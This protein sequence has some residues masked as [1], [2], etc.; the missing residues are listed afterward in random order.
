M[1]EQLTA[2]YELQS[3]D[4]KIVHIRTA[5]AGFDGAKVLKQQLAAAKSTAE[6]AHA[7]LTEYETELKDSELRLK[8]IDDK[9]GSVEK[10]LY[11]G[12]VSNTR[13]LQALEKEVK[14]L[15]E[16]QGELD[17]R[18]LELYDL[19]ES[20]R[21]EA[22]LGRKAADQLEQKLGEALTQESAERA[23][24]EG[25]LA[26]L[27]SQRDSAAS[28]LTDKSLISRYD[29]VRG[30]TRGTGIAKVVHG[31]C[32][33]CR[34]AITEFMRRKL[35]EAEGFESCENCGR[36]LMLDTQ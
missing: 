20:A 24:L 22:R 31:K 6:G 23:R 2:L 30:R 12:T 26:E 3:L 4:T 21:E 19:V 15:K 7:K 28:A 33:A 10:R 25:E 32:E 27:A 29:A 18:T 13:E 16:Q 14:L 1:K 8:S 17:G 34:V 35:E 9:R 36:I 5:L 11:G